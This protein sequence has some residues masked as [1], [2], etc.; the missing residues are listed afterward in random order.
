M[1][2]KAHLPHQ[3]KYLAGHLRFLIVDGRF[4]VMLKNDLC[5]WINVQRIDILEKLK[6]YLK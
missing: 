3:E 2:E 4:V 6:Y 5:C 1:H